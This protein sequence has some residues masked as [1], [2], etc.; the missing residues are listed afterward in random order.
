MLRLL[1]GLLIAGASILIGCYLSTRLKK[2]CDVL[3]DYAALLDEAANRMS[4][5]GVNLAGAFR[6]NFAG[7][8]FDPSLAFA[9]Q[10]EEMTRQFRDVLNDVDRRTLYDF[11]RELG[12]GDISAELN[13][14]RL[15]RSVLEERLADAR[16][17]Y[18]KKG[19][20]CRVLPFSVGLAIAVLIL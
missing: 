8:A 13:R 2:R 19:A 17:N 6:D 4:Y 3:A 10:W 20:V 16:V 14:I 1:A 11:A 7:F 18:E 5:S 15:Y 12:S 9:P